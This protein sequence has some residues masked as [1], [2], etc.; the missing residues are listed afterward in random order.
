[1]TSWMGCVACMDDMIT[2]YKIWSGNPQWK[3]TR[4]KLRRT[5]NDNIEMGLRELESEAEDSTEVTQNGI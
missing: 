1:M 2:A 4:E 5:W 3:M